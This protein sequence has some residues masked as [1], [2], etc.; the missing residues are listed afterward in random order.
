[1]F[2]FAYL[3]LLMFML[4]GMYS[5]NAFADNET[6]RLTKA[7]GAPEW[8]TI[9]GEH[10]TRYETLNNQYRRMVNGRATNGG[11]Q[12]LVF[13]TLVHARVDLDLVRIGAEM[14]DSRVRLTDSGS[15]TSATRL[16]P[17][18]ANPFE[19]LQAY[20]E[21]PF[22]NFIV[23]G[24]N[25]ILRAGRITMDLGS[26][27]LLARN[28]YRN[29]INGFNGVDWQWQHEDRKFRAFYTLPV[30]RLVDEQLIDNKTKF[31]REDEAT[32]FWG[33]YYS[34]ALLSDVDMAEAFIL[35]LNE[36]DSKRLP[37]KNRDLYT[38]GMRFWRKPAVGQ[39][40]YQLESIYQLGESRTT[41][42]STK[43]LEHWAHFQ[44]AELGYSFNAPW[45]PRLIAQY[46]FASGDEN[47]ND[48]ENNRFDTLYGGR[49]FDFG[50]T[51]IFAS[52]P[53]SNVQS[54]ALRLMLKP[55]SAVSAMF[56][57]RG[58]WRASNTD[59]WSTAGIN[60][61]SSFIGTQ[62]ETRL[63]WQLINNLQLEGGVA[64][65]IA[66]DLMS[67]ARKTDSTIAYSQVTVKF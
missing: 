63:R 48:K 37:S 33:V 58:F 56:A 67:E 19:L 66:G 42:N 22:E 38:F 51:S 45:K 39:F 43:S 12:A 4:L 34:Q 49:R 52:F 10:R 40:D 13:R 7:L 5:L 65:L 47:P 21:V 60:G 16:T 61:R 15:A 26:R 35:G 41:T 3:R 59:S 31:D 23:D 29:T 17:T 46:D 54:P 28:R 53:R 24:S 18:I 6:W 57:V 9:E 50:P 62:M 2:Y 11:D 64:H 30:R 20:I 25:S 27:R 14:M 36:N 44:H 55:H 8:L 1:M 32:R